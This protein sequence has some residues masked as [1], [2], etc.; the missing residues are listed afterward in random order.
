MNRKP[1]LPAHIMIGSAFMF[2]GGIAVIR[3]ASIIE[4]YFGN[5]ITWSWHRE[6]FIKH[7]VF[8]GLMVLIG[9]FIIL[10]KKFTEHWPDGIC[11]SAFFT[12]LI[13]GFLFLWSHIK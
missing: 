8:A 13:M 5:I 6:S 12:I 7:G 3:M 1:G 4:N 9:S 2:V 10:R 11:T